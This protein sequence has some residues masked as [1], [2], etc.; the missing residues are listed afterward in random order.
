MYVAV[1]IEFLGASHRNWTK[2]HVSNKAGVS[3]DS[4]KIGKI[5]YYC[6]LYPC[7]CGQKIF[8][9]NHLRL[10]G[11]DVSIKKTSNCQIVL[12]LEYHNKKV[13]FL[14]MIICIFQYVRIMNLSPLDILITMSHTTDAI[15]VTS[16]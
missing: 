9:E 12:V 10:S 13:E 6:T 4:W 1:S 11:K 8:S 3:C 5:S 15:T 16:Y 7:S 2:E 14:K